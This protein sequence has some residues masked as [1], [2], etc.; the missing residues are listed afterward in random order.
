MITNLLINS[1]LGLLVLRIAIGVIFLFH[2][3][4]KWGMWKMSPSDKM[5]AKMISI[6]KILSVVEPLGALAM[7]VGFLTQ[8]A[9]IGLGIIMIGAIYF[10]IKIFKVPFFTTNN[11]GW[12]FD[13]LILA[14]CIAL[15]FLGAGS[16]SLDGMIFS[17]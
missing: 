4:M 17:L 10:K 2:G 1:D 6:M 15:L 11:T 12:E 3:K 8:F 5:P 13:F 16:L 14:T 7:F 9:A